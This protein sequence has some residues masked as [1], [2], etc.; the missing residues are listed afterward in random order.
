MS[1]HDQSP[2]WPP[3]TR[4]S[5]GCE[6]WSVKPGR[7]TQEK[8]HAASLVDWQRWALECSSCLCRPITAARQMGREAVLS[9]SIV[10]QQA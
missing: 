7:C 6:T 3:A 9:L 10:R 4:P 8:K 2:T 1:A 5:A